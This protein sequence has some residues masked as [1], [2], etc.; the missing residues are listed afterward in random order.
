MPETTRSFLTMVGLLTVVIVCGYTV[1]K[2]FTIP[3]PTSLSCKMRDAYPYASVL[4]LAG[5][6]VLIRLNEEPGFGTWVK[7]VAPEFTCEAIFGDQW[8]DTSR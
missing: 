3:S 2:F 7:G 8:Y 1:K 4:R 5:N 6:K